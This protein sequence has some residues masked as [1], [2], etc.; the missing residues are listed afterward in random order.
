MTSVQATGQKRRATY[1]DVI[2]APPLKIA[3]VIDGRLY[4]Q[5]RPIIPHSMARS[6]LVYQLGILYDADVRSEGK[7]GGW[8][9]LPQIEVHFR[10]PQDKDI[11]V[12]DIAGWRRENL[13]QI[14]DGDYMTLAPDWVC[15][16]LFPFTRKMDLTL[17]RD[18]YA[19]EGVRHLWFM[20]PVD[21][22]LEAF[23]LRD[24]QWTLLGTVVDDAPVS[25]PPFDAASFSLASIWPENRLKKRPS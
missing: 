11:I 14:P 21:H 12:P 19:R 18:L 23:E 6:A 20:D 5:D 10:T 17:K 25:L 3:E 16:V 2:D 9:F 7:P 24:G 4:L 1:Q 22:I 15:E 8:W 13:P